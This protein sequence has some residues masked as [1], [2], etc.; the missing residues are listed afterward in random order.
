MYNAGVARVRRGTPYS[1]L[2]Y[3]ARILDNERQLLESF[4]QM[5][6]GNREIASSS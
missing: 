3:V 4:K 6:T 1:T 2:H 5:L